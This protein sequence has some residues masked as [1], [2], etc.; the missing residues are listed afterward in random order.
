MPK[1]TLRYAIIGFG[2]IAENR[3]AKEGFARDASRFRPLPGIELAAAA[4]VSP[5]RRAAAESL[6]LTWYDS[7]EAVLSDP[8]I[9]AV[10]IAS[11]NASH[12]SLGKK[13]L[14]AGKHVIL[15]KPMATRLDD[16]RKLVALAAARGLSL[17]VDHMMLHNAHN[18]KARDLVASGAL[19]DV[20]DI[21]LHMEFY[22]GS[23]PGE[24][25]AWRCARPSELGG[26]IGDVGS[27]CLYMAEFLLGSPVVSVAAVFTPRTIKIRAENGAFIRFETASGLTGSSRV[28]FNDPRG[29]L[30]GTLLNLG[31][32]V[33]GTKAALRSYGTL[34]QLSGHQ[35]EPVRIRL[36]LEA[37]GA[38]LR[39]VRVGQVKNI[40]QRIILEHAAAIRSGR[41][42]TGEDGLHNLALVEACYQSA[43]QGGKAITVK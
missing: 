32:E 35:G 3:I 14:E 37:G 36:E 43:A 13:A 5:A 24:A 34:F 41:R 15:E 22:Y 31:F 6:G 18:A 7:P 2:G 42:L 17:S 27:H 8:S 38:A 40:Y 9:D 10:F 20:N 28:S 26:P 21:V 19:G 29:S 23:T 4:D 1:T 11:N 25:A 39:P 16:A 12:Y 33:Y 30:A